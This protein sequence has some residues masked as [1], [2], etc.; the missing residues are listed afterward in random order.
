MPVA[1][2][3]RLGRALTP[4]AHDSVLVSWS[5]S[6]FEYLMPDLVLRA[7]AGSLLEQSSRLVVRRQIL[8]GAERGV[9]WGVSESA[10]NARDLEQTYQYSNFGVPGLG[11]RRGL[12]ED[13]VV[14]PYATGLAAM[15]DPAAA[16]QIRRLA[17]AGASGAY[18]YYDALDFTAAR[19]PEGA[20]VALVRTY[21][22]HHQG[23]LLVAIA[24]VL[25]DGVMRSR[26]HAEPIVQATELLLQERTPRAVAVARP[27]AE[28]VAAVTDV[29]AFVP[30]VVRRFTAPRGPV[31][32][33]L[34]SNG[35]Y[36]V[37]LTT[38]GSGYSRWQDIAVTRWREDSTRDADGTHCYLSDPRS[39]RTWSAGY[40]PTGAEPDSYEVVFAEDR[41]KIV[42]RDGAIATTLDV[43][44]SP[45]DDAE[46]R[47]VTLTNFGP[48]PR[49]IELTTYAEVVLTRPAADAAHPAFSNLFV[50]TEAVPE[51]DTLL[52]TRR[53]RAP[54]EP[55]LWLAHV[56]AVD[57]RRIGALQWETDR[58]L[59][60]GRGRG[61]REPLAMEAG[62]N[63]TNSVGAVLDPIVSLRLRV[64]LRP[65]VAVRVAFTTL[66]APTRE[67]AIDLAEKYHD[68]ATF[69]RAATLAWTQAG[70]DAPRRDRAGRGAH[71]PGPGPAHRVRR[72][73]PRPAAD[74]L[75]RQAGG[76]AA[77]W[78]HGI[79]G[80]LPIVVVQIDQARRR[81]RRPPAAARARY[82]RL[83]QLAVDLVILNV[84]APSYVQDLQLLLETMVPLRPV[85]RAGGR[86]HAARGGVFLPRRPDAPGA[87]GRPPVR[88]PR[89]AL[90]PPRHAR[91]T[92]RALARA[93]GGRALFTAP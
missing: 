20:R 53:P 21:M 27:R 39:G 33:H 86:A 54:G 91:R 78:A 29:R 59:F 83:K 84:R 51:M 7:P 2:W 61:V 76:P 88:R 28:E 58:A 56:A 89:R 42:R 85:G 74:V 45:E 5:G 6:M 75:L 81:R 71:V 12:K 72:A 82:W 37:M 87:A 52:A 63:L 90:Q 80:D 43:I 24:N 1:H 31:R 16:A 23:L 73:Q 14:A 49:E 92:D 62:R 15:F 64:R 11:L 50:D 65:G 57:G 48:Q 30:P 47:R 79:S 68:P 34:L 19:L 13:V 55:R 26:F 32:T 44:V 9:P 10:Y 8:Y 67:A 69:D 35:A 18:G 25:L 60:L 93:R 40:Q 22:A 41:A 66:V 36:A 77:L 4:V 17:E 70:A 3:F 38:A 46:I